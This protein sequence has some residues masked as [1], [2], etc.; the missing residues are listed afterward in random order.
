[1]FNFYFQI[2]F[3]TKNNNEKKKNPRKEKDFTKTLFGTTWS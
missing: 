1:M 3:P 2:D